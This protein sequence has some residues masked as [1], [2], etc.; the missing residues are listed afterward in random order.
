MWRFQREFQIRR[1]LTIIGLHGKKLLLRM[2][3]RWNE[4]TTRYGTTLNEIFARL[5][6]NIHSKLYISYFS[7]H[8]PIIVEIDSRQC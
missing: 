6:E 3:N 8:K 7:Y 5:I 4:G 2:V 1:C